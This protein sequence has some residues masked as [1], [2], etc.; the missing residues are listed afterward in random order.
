[1]EEDGDYIEDDNFC[2]SDFEDDVS[3]MVGVE[4]FLQGVDIGNLGFQET[5]F[6]SSNGES[7]EDEE[8]VGEEIMEPWEEVLEEGVEHV[9]IGDSTPSSIFQDIPIETFPK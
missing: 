4:E 9:N 7:D 3:E 2:P 1:M 5:H 8:D 6:L